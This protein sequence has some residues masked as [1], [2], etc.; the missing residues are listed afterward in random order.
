MID[1]DYVQRV[2]KNIRQCIEDIKNNW[3][4]DIGRDY[5]R[6]LDES[7]LKL[8]QMEPDRIKMVERARAIQKYCDDIT[9]EG[10]PPKV[11]DR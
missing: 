11:L 4:D 9:N 10:D 2:L 7:V 1:Y 6:Y 8:E 5:A 3:R